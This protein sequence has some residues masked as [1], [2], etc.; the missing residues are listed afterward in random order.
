MPARATR[1]RPWPPCARSPPRAG[2]TARPCAQSRRTFRSPPTRRGSGSSTRR[3]RS[4]EPRPLPPAVDGLRPRTSPPPTGSRESLEQI[5]DVLRV[6]AVG[7]ELERL[8]QVGLRLGVLL[9]LHL[10]EPAVVIRIGQVGL[11]RDGLVQGA[12]GLC[13]PL[14]VEIEDPDVQVRLRVLD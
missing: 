6:G 5:L 14:L 3:P 12:H 8:A 1:P 10:A 9:Q 13:G 4:S 11:D 7:G 2:S